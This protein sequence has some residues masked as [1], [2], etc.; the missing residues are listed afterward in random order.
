MAWSKFLMKTRVDVS[1][2]EFKALFLYNVHEN[3]RYLWLTLM[4]YVGVT[5]LSK[6]YFHTTNSLN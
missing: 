5:E 4:P 3:F 2:N 1:G 6:G